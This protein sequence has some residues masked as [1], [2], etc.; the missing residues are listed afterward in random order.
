MIVIG[1]LLIHWL[2]YLNNEARPTDTEI[3]VVIYDVSK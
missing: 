1:W 2:I 3:V